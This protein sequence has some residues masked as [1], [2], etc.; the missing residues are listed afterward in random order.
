MSGSSSSEEENYWPGYVDALT[1]MVMVLTFIMMVLGIAIFTLSQN[2][3]RSYLESIAKAA[4]MEAGAG[5]GTGPG[6]L[7]E[8]K[9]RI[10]AALEAQSRG[11]VSS[12]GTSVPPPTLE[13]L[14]DAAEMAP[15]DATERT[16][17]GVAIDLKGVEK[18]A[19]VA[20][21]DTATDKAA[22]GVGP[23]AASPLDPG[24]T[25]GDISERVVGPNPDATAPPVVATPSQAKDRSAETA[26]AMV[27][28]QNVSD[29]LSQIAA[30]S[31]AVA[32]PS[33]FE[34]RSDSAVVETKEAPKNASVSAFGPLLTVTYKP[35]AT[36]LD[37]AAMAEV[38]TFLAS[39]ILKTP[40]M[41]LVVKSYVPRGGAVTEARRTAYYRSMLVRQLLTESGVAANQIT[42]RIEDSSDPKQSEVT[43]V[44][45]KR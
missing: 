6:S 25:K 40:K 19:A 33:P 22:A 21:P 31:V 2:V 10:V 13:R 37:E 24:T 7:D 20:Q 29:D 12:K 18:Q 14:P 35:R 41:N 26:A 44:F 3:S 34:Q 36:R 5:S 38:K 15:P 39:P 1:T 43:Q 27:P 23:A 17:G 9:Q 45:E 30:P 11:E 8:L 4:G 32:T 16:N 42:V 28:E